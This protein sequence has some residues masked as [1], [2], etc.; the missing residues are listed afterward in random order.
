MRYPTYLARSSV[1]LLILIAGC[2]NNAADD[3][4]TKN[5]EKTPNGVQNAPAKPEEVARQFLDATAKQD[6]AGVKKVVTEK[7]KPFIDKEGVPPAN[8]AEYELKQPEVQGK[9][10]RVPYTARGLTAHVLLKMENERWRVHGVSMGPLVKDFENPDKKS[11]FQ[12]KGNVGDSGDVPDFG[13]PFGDDDEQQKP[14]PPPLKSMSVADFNAA[15]K[16]DFTFKDQPARE[17]LAELA[18]KSGLEFSERSARLSELQKPVS[19]DLKQASVA[20]AIEE[21]CQQIGLH[22][23]YQSRFRGKD[24]LV[25][26]RGARPRPPAYAGPYAVAADELEVRPEYA[27]GTL[28][29][30]IAG[31]NLLDVVHRLQEENV[32][33][34]LKIEAVTGSNGGEL[35]QQRGSVHFNTGQLQIP[36]KIP[37][38]NL[39][40]EVETLTVRGKISVPIPEEVQQLRFTDLT[41]GATKTAGDVK[42]TLKQS[43]SQPRTRLELRHNKPASG[44]FQWTA[45]DAAGEKLQVGRAGFRST[46]V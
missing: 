21:V 15:W 4:E 12:V 8:P 7:S 22:P 43:E 44:R 37:L 19:L 40:R 39:L 35:R 9:T 5:Q 24:Q 6:V 32:S 17:V 26:R 13:N 28:K 41:P 14:A 30:T 1:A 34:F 2:S 42:V 23:T 16:S 20:R 33:Q 10:A 27:T 29:L 18:E 31:F 3:A 25:L 11:S 46:I 38:K 36:L 45:L